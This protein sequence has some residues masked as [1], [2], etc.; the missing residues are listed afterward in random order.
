MAKV[1]ITRQVKN[2]ASNCT[3]S[4]RSIIDQARWNGWV[5]QALYKWSTWL[6]CHSTS[7]LMM[8]P[9]NVMWNRCTCAISYWN[10]LRNLTVE[11]FIMDGPTTIASSGRAR[12]MYFV[13]WFPSQVI[14][15]KIQAP[16][17]HG[18]PSKK[19]TTIRKPKMSA[20]MMSGHKDVLLA[21][22]SDMRNTKMKLFC[23][24]THLVFLVLRVVCCGNLRKCSP[25]RRHRVYHHYEELSIE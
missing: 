24:M 1:A 19:R 11:C 12:Y 21:T 10:V 22:K 4:R 20:S 5:T 2:N 9:W 7:A 16:P 25:S 6:K 3:S 23:L 8:I 18:E 17:N 15:N 13:L 14:A